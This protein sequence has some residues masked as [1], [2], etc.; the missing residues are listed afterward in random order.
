MMKTLR[1]LFEEPATGVVPGTY[2]PHHARE[3]VMD[4]MRHI[5]DP[6]NSIEDIM[7]AL[8]RAVASEQDQVVRTWLCDTREAL[9]KRAPTMLYVA[10]EM[11]IRGRQSSLRDCLRR[12]LGVITRCIE[13][14]DFLEGVRAFMIDKDNQPKWAPHSL[15]EVREDRVQHYLRSPWDATTHLFNDVE[16]HYP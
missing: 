14:G 7:S 3:P 5:F 13:D 9:L 4:H 10:R 8:C 16:V 2:V 15:W 11:I 1:A 12:E 6:R